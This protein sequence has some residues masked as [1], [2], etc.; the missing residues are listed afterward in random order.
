[1]A[2]LSGMGEEADREFSSWWRASRIY[3]AT[4]YVTPL[5]LQHVLV[6]DPLHPQFGIEFFQAITRITSGLMLPLTTADLLANAIIGS[7]L[8]NLDMESLVRREFSL[9]LSR[10]TSKLI[11]RQKSGNRWRIG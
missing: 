6:S 5:L 7:V 4:R 2:P 8:E 10:S 3:R 11:P 1:M 9:F